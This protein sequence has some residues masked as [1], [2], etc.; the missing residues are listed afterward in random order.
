VEFAGEAKDGL[1]V[2]E[3]HRKITKIKRRTQGL[4]LGARNGE[5]S[6][7]ERDRQQGAAVA[8]VLRGG[9]A[10]EREER[11][12]GARAEEEIRR[13]LYRAEGEG[14]EACKAVGG[15]VGG[16]GH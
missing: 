1:P 9:C 12:G 10:V 5:R 4:Y 7:G 15:E 2:T 3:S 16:A 11:K 8:A 14:E 13:T 6:G